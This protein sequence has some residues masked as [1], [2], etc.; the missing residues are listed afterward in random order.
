MKALIL[1]TETTGLDSKKDCIIEVAGILVDLNH[2]RI[3]CQRSGLIYAL[4]NQDSE[5]IT[6]ISQLMLDG[7]KSAFDDPFNS[8]KIMAEQSLCVI[9]HNAEFDKSFVEAR[10]IILNNKNNLPLEWI[11]SYRDINY[12]IQTENKKLGTLAEAYSVDSGGAH[13]ALSDVT[14]LAQILFKVPNIEEQVFSAIENKKKPEVK[15]ISLAPFEMK[16]D[17]KKAGFRWNPNDKT[18][19][20]NIRA[21]NESEVN[22]I[23]GSF[24]FDVKMA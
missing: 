13:R 23:I 20:K 14:M 6:G 15:I 10:G 4:T 19:W 17:V 11:C 2:K 12:D 1:D 24:G 8:I 16:E 3:E 21:A 5:K 22:K 18:W 7:V 9:A